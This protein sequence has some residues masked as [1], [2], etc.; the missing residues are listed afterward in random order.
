MVLL[1]ERGDLDRE[2]TRRA[3]IA[4][5]Q[6]RKRQPLPVHLQSPPEAWREE[7]PPMAREAGL[8]VEDIDEAFTALVEFW[9]RL[10]PFNGVDA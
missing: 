6:L 1:I 2:E 3:I 4:T 9:N 8:S 5:F 10:L 7:F